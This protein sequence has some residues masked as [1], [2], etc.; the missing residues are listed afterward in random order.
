MAYLTFTT[1][2]GREL[3]QRPLKGAV[4]IG[5]SPECEIC[6]HDILLSRRHCQIEQDG[7]R[8]IVLDLMSKNGT[9]FGPREIGRHELSDGDSIRVGKT[10][11]KFCAGKMAATKQGGAAMNRPNGPTRQRAADPWEAMQATVAGF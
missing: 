5:R 4:V 7:S 11:V 8:W 10:V 2:R 6:I 9:F 3:G 1:V